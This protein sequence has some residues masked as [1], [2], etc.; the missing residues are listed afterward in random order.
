MV[1]VGMRCLYHVHH[2]CCRF[3]FIICD[4]MFNVVV[5]VG[6]YVHIIIRVCA[7]RIASQ[8]SHHECVI[9]RVTV[10]DERVHGNNGWET[11]RVR[12]FCLYV[13]MYDVCTCTPYMHCIP[14]VHVMFTCY[15]LRMHT[16]CTVC[17][18]LF[19]PICLSHARMIRLSAFLDGWIPRNERKKEEGEKKEK[20][21][22]LTSHG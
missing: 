18:M 17:V 2:V 5:W 19:T 14:C 16:V 13:D 22:V 11:P 3:L 9:R 7:Y 4:V 8:H 10:E 15:S 6:V 21:H 20:N 12:V 1:S